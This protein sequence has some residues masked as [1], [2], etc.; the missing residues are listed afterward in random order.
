VKYPKAEQHEQEISNV[1]DLELDF[2]E[3]DRCKPVV[4]RLSLAGTLEKPLM[5][6]YGIKWREGGFGL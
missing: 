5:S 6:L 2:A 4:M 1:E 3:S